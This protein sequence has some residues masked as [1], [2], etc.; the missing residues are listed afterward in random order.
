MLLFKDT[1]FNKSKKFNL[2]KILVISDTHS[3]IDDKIIS[4]VKKTDQVWHAG[5]VGNMSILD[6]LKN[7]KKTIAVFG[8]IDNNILRKELKEHELFYCEKI[9]VLI[10]HIA[11]K[12]PNYNKKTR[13]LIKL[14]K[15]KILVCGHSHI[16]K[17]NYDKKNDLLCI[18]PGAAGRH[19][20]HKKRTIVRFEIIEDNIQKMEIIELGDR[21]V[22]S[23]PVGRANY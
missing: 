6:Q 23:N 21:S 5:D 15:P 9:K 13:E 14:E 3:H 7:L 11:G 20:F 4:Y 19:G 2:K 16:L 12:T 1:L 17:V 18:N 22:L 8:N 10:T